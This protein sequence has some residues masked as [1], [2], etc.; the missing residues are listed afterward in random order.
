MMWLNAKAK[1]PQYAGDIFRWLGTVEGQVAYANV[2]SSAD[3]A[4]FPESIKLAK[5]SDRAKI[6]LKM[7]EDRVRV[8]PNPLVRQPGLS[9]VAA[10]YVDPTPNLAQAVQGL[11]SGQLS[12]V[13]ATL[14]KASDARNKAL[15]TAIAKAKAAGAGVSRDDFVFTSWDP[16]RDFGPADYAK[17]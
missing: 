14:K 9:K 4:I 3:P 2:A 1:N 12:G 7:A 6:M 15:D 11:F 13:K 8:A 10:A 5:L 17:L 16:S